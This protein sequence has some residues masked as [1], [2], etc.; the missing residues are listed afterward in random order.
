M[1][2]FYRCAHCSNLV[3]VINDGS[4][5]P[6]C[7]GEPMKL[8]KAGETDGAA[9][10]HVPV[11]GVSGNEVAVKV[12]EVAHPMT[13]EHLIQWIALSA[14]GRIDIRKLTKDD[15]PEAVFTLESEGPFIVYEYCN[16]HGLWKSEGKKL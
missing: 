3:Y 5:N 14:N 9:E 15:R 2:L 11:I 1:D 6:V 8:L 4:V 7:C 16:L 10:K 13:E 12:G